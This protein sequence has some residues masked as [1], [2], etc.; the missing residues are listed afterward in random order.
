MSRYGD[1]DYD[2]M[3]YEIDEFL[4]EH[5]PSELL[6]LVHDAVEMWENNSNEA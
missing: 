5:K 6:E 1:A 2:D 4:K 3:I